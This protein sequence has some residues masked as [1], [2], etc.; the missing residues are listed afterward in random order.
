MSRRGRHALGADDD[1]L[2]FRTLGEPD[3]EPA[4]DQDGPQLLRRTRHKWDQVG[5]AEGFLLERTT[6]P[7]V[8]ARAAAILLAPRGAPLLE[9]AAG[10][11]ADVLL[12]GSKVWCRACRRGWVCSVEEPYLNPS[13]SSDLTSAQRRRSGICAACLVL[14]ESRL[15]DAVQPSKQQLTTGEVKDDGA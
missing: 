12:E 9:R 8:V 5:R 3:P 1:T 2:D 6:M 4:P 13:P 7:D 11:R 10:G 15:D 14:T